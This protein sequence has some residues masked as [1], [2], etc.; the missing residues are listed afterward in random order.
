MRGGKRNGAGR[1]PSGRFGSRTQVATMRV[2]AQ[3][4]E[5]MEAL[6]RAG[7]KPSEIFEAAIHRA[8][9]SVR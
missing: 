9:L 3:I 4:K 1:K 5:E 2:S 7:R 8:W 6:R